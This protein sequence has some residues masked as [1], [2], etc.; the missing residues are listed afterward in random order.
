MDPDPA[1]WTPTTDGVAG[2]SVVVAKDGVE[3][4]IDR[5]T[6]TIPRSLAAAGRLFARLCVLVV[7]WILSGW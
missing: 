1:G 6:V 2:V 7:P 5:V 3:P 4:G